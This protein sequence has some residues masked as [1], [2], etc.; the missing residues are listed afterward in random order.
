CNADKL[1]RRTLAADVGIERGS[2]NGGQKRVVAA[3]YEGLD[4]IFND[5][6]MTLRENG[7]VII[8]SEAVVVE[9]LSYGEIDLGRDAGMTV[10]AR[11]WV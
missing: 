11:L 8:G 3:F 2:E 9:P 6:P 10:S 1:Y 5:L 4:E 7:D